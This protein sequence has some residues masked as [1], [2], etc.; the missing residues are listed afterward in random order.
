MGATKEK[1]CIAI[2]NPIQPTTS[3]HIRRQVNC[4]WAH[5]QAWCLQGDL[6]FN[7]M[8]LVHNLILPTLQIINI[9]HFFELN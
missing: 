2:L 9:I 7:V 8:F 5:E 6:Q 4:T 3:E 1:T